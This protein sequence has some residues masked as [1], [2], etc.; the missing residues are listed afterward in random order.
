MSIHW[1][2]PSGTHGMLGSG[3]SDQATL[4]QVDLAQSFLSED[5]HAKHWENL[6]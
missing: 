1:L 4:A 6:L 5:V 2:G 3:S